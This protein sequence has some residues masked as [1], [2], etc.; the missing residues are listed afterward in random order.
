MFGGVCGYNKFTNEIYLLDV[1][2]KRWTKIIQ[3]GTAPLPIAWHT[4]TVIKQTMFVIGGI[5]ETEVFNNDV[6]ALDLSTFVWSKL[7]LPSGIC[8]IT[9]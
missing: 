8:N 3:S 7:E 2:K 9:F 6:F 4:S 5:F 1:E